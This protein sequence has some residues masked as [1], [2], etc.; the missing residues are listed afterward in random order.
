MEAIIDAQKHTPA[1]VKQIRQTQANRSVSKVIFNQDMSHMAIVWS[2]NGFTKYD[3]NTFK[4]IQ[5][6]DTDSQITALALHHKTYQ[7]MYVTIEEPNVLR[8]KLR[9]FKH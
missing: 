8:P 9:V 1:K 7:F 2:E 4:V 6:F 3:V 5:E